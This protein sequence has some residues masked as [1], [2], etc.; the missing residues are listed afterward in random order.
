MLESLSYSIEAVA[1]VGI[2][3]VGVLVVVL[4]QEVFYVSPDLRMSELRK[5]GSVCIPFR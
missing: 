1:G 5:Q 3:V 4:A 2:V